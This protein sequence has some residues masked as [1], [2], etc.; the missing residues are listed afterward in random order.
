MD[1]GH[2]GR[3]HRRSA[4]PWRWRSTAASAVPSVFRTIF[5]SPGGAAAGRGRPDLGVDVQ[6]AFRRGERLALKAIGLDRLARGWLSDYD[7]ALAA[8]FI[9]QVWSHAGF[10]MILYLAGLQAI[11]TR[12]L[13]GRP[14]RRRH[15]LAL[16]PPRHPAGPRRDPRHRAFAWQSFSVQG[17]RPH[18]HDDLWRT[19][20]V[21]P[22]ARHLDVFPDLPVLQRGLRR[23]DLAWVIAAI[24]LVDRGSLYPPDVARLTGSG[25]SATSAVARPRRVISAQRPCSWCLAL[26]ARLADALRHDPP[27][28]DPQP[29][30]PYQPRRLLDPEPNSS[31]RT[32]STPGR[33]A[34]SPIYFKN[35]LLLIA[36]KVPLGILIASLAAYPLAK[37][38]FRAR[39]PSSSSSWSG[40]RCRCRSPCSRCWS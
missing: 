20:S 24:V 15:R 40:S 7:T 34:T 29:G 14:H 13:R 12:A 33:P 27:L 19:R 21:D 39:M 10:P 35:S 31:G 17:F 8:T 36:V 16:L 25:Q 18:L 3:A 23:R 5:Y 4:S 22:G 11:P 32:S 38:R 6:S 26:R 28:G 30:R 9:T 37:M 2:A 1:S